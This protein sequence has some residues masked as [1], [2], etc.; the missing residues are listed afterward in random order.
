MADDEGGPHAA[1]P[2]P[3]WGVREAVAGLVVAFLASAI[4]AAAWAGATGQ[5]TLDELSL[6]GLALFQAVLWLG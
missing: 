4:A 5:Q 3:R 1:S 2:A 6:A